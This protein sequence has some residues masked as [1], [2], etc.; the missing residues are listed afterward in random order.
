MY[1]SKL[2]VI[3]DRKDRKRLQNKDF[4]ILCTNCIG[5]VMYHHL[6]L[7]FLSPTIN[8]WIAPSDFIKLL[9]K[10]SKYLS[11]EMKEVSETGVNYP[12]GKLEDITIFG[13]HYDS[14]DELKEKWNQRKNRINWD[15]TY[16]FMIERDRCT[17]Q[18]LVDFDKLPYVNKVVFTKDDYPEIESA[19][20]LP[21]S[22]DS[23]NDEVNNLLQY[24]SRFSI[25]QGIDEFDYVNFINGNGRQLLS[26]KD[27][28]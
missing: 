10:P 6:G 5:G 15:N 17:Y 12:V 16:L 28:I 25:L 21:N 2:R 4:T 9:K 24:K 13:Q 1:L 7:K 14:F 23:K 18:D 8:L 20:K 22:Y 19:I 11:S 26:F 27:K 3:K